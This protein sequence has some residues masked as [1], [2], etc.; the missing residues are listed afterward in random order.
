MENIDSADI[1]YMTRVQQE[2]FSDPIEYEKVK[3]CYQLDA[4]MLTG[5]KPNMK[6]LHPLPRLTEI[7]IDVDDTPHA[8]YFTQAE[9]GVYVR[10][11]I[12]TYLL[13]IK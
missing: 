12:I 5:A 11:A 8:Y 2:R 1:L 4:S 9:N 7:N 13:G 6:I 10:M 3:Y